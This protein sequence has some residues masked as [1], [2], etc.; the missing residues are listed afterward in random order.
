LGFH[1]GFPIFFLAILAFAGGATVFT[2]GERVPGNVIVKYKKAP[3]IASSNSSISTARTYIKSTIG[4]RRIKQIHSLG[5]DKMKLRDSQDIDKTIESIN[6]LSEVEYAEPDYIVKAVEIPDDIDSQIP[7]L[8]EDHSWGLL[9]ISANTAWDITTG[10]EDV[11]VAIIDS[12]ID[13]E[14]QDLSENIWINRAEDINGDG[15]CTVDDEDGKD[16][17]GNGYTDDCVGWNFV[18]GN[19][20]PYDDLDHGTHV[21]GIVGGIGFE[22]VYGVSRVLKL[23]AV[24]FIASDGYGSTSNAISAIMYAVKNGARILNNS[25]GGANYSRSLKDAIAYSNE[26]E[27]LFV[28]AAGNSGENNDLYPHYPSNYS[29]VN[30]LSVGASDAWNDMPYFSNFGYDSVDVVA[31][32]IFIYSTVSN[33][34]YSIFSGTSMATPFASGVAALVLAENPGM[35][36]FDLKRVVMESTDKFSYLSGK[37]LTGGRINANSALV[38]AAS[39]LSDSPEFPMTSRLSDPNERGKEVMAPY[40][41]GRISGPSGKSSDKLMIFVLIFLPLII[42]VAKKHRNSVYVKIGR[43]FC[44]FFF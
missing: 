17:D 22:E 27:A 10:S 18:S 32:G 15:F 44:R 34:S 43:N 8:S 25:W 42:V 4:I 13:Y 40:G 14:H 29:V 28:A 5:L 33:N 41:C 36:T 3:G 23:M 20:D 2:T 37:I 12:G 26:Q 1:W 6:S 30:V 31:P 21:A 19:N 11:V 39:G 38:L 35:S 24:K 16:Q 9:N 7:R